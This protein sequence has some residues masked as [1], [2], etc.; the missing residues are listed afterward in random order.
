MKTPTQSLLSAR[1]SL[2]LSLLLAVA[3]LTGCASMLQQTA[4]HQAASVVDYLYPKASEAPRMAPAMA[5]LHPPIR[6]GLAF[7]PDARWNGNFVPEA[8]KARLLERV[9]KAFLKY[10]FI[11]SI[12]LIPSDY[13]RPGGGFANLEQAA[14]MFNVEVVALISY[15]QVQF[16]DVSSLA[17]LYWTVIGAYIIHGDQYDIETLLDA[18]IFDVASHKLL[19]RAPGT[20]RIK[21]SAS[22]SGFSEAARAARMDGYNQAVDDLNLKLAAELERFRE[23]IKTD[24]SVRVVNPPGN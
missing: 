1:H 4:P 10:P 11:A 23:R 2:A 22:L 9:R 6:V 18:S 12:E 24:G 3:L 20:S 5:T 14:R 16:N 13:L 19:F 15:D 7:A 17:V 8:D 21:G